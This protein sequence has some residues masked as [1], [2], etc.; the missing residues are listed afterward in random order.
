MFTVMML[1][2]VVLIEWYPRGCAEEDDAYGKLVGA[3]AVNEAL[4]F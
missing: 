2:K 4:S 1:G 3:G